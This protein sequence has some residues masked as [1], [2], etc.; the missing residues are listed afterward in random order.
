MLAC[1]LYRFAHVGNV[2]A[3]I[4]F[5]RKGV[6]WTVCPEVLVGLSINPAPV[7]LSRVLTLYL[8]PFPSRIFCSSFMRPACLLRMQIFLHSLNISVVHC[9]LPAKMSVG[10]WWELWVVSLRGC[11]CEC[12]LKLI[13]PA[14]PGF[15]NMLPRVMDW[16]IIQL[17]NSCQNFPHFYKAHFKE[18]LRH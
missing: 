13:I 4:L 12:S 9:E 8:L 16:I 18:I 5:T 1:S 6:Q 10:Q 2:D 11:V 3:P 7:V 15:E 17:Q 14:S